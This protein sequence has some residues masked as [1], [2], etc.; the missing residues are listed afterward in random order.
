MAK[1]RDTRTLDLFRDYEP[2]EARLDPEITRGGTLD[3]KI[4]R[5][6]SHAMYESDKT[7]AVIAE[8]MSE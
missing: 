4:A 1:Q 8:E 2:P 5:A 7:R 6:L 3:V